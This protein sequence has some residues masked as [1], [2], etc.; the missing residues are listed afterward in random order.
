MKT[1]SLKIDLPPAVFTR[2]KAAAENRGLS[3]SQFISCM[4]MW[5]A[6]APDNSE[7]QLKAKIKAYLDGEI[8]VDDAVAVIK[9]LVGA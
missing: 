6:P 2:V 1:V 8:S 5:H 4:A 9:G 3:P 7:Q